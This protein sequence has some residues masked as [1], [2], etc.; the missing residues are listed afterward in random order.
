MVI[1]PLGFL[2]PE[3]LLLKKPLVLCLPDETP[4][5]SAPP[6]GLRKKIHAIISRCLAEKGA[7]VL[8]C[9]EI[10]QSRLFVAKVPIGSHRRCAFMPCAAETDRADDP[11]QHSDIAVG[12]GAKS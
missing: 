2:F 7:M 6:D 12:T 5:T 4:S 9:S 1:V 8:A 3:A 11:E 10:P